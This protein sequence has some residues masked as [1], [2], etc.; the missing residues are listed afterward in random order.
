[1]GKTILDQL[2]SYGIPIQSP[3]ELNIY[4]ESLPAGQLLEISNGYSF[5]KS[6]FCDQEWKL[7]HAEILAFLKTLPEK[8]AIEL[9]EKID[10]QDW[11]WNWL[12]KTYHL[13]TDDCNEWFYLTIDSK[14]EAACLIYFPKDSFLNPSENIFYVEYLAVAPWNRYTPIEDQ[15]YKRLGSLLL[16]KSLNYL[17]KKYKNSGRF[18]LHSLIQ[19][20]GYYINKLKMQHVQSNDKPSL[21]YFEL[22]D[23]EVSNIIGAVA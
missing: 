17:A 3:N 20:E 4:S 15:R 5:E 23:H 21:K 14:V 16:L 2:K 19:A 13:K 11:H 10:S 18:S 6:L 8:N 9:A 7:Y 12:N 22:P 1:M